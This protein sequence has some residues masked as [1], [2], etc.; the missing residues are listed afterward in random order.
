[1]KNRA[2]DDNACECAPNIFMI[3]HLTRGFYIH[4]DRL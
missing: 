3:W 2:Y 1:M 4:E